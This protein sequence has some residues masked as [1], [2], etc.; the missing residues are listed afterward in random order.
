M[1]GNRLLNKGV[2]DI[3]GNGFTV[4]VATA[5]VTEPQGAAPVTITRYLFPLMLTG[6][7]VMVKVEV[8]DP[9]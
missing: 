9:L 2:T 3:T 6:G 4:K 1:P 8:E 5:E 7:A